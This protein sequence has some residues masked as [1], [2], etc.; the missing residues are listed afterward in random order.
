M[1]KKIAYLCIT[2]VVLAAPA[3]AKAQPIGAPENITL[4]DAMPKPVDMVPMPPALG[5]DA[6][7]EGYAAAAA[8]ASGMPVSD[9]NAN[10]TLPAPEAATGEDPQVD[11]AAQ[12]RETNTEAAAVSAC[13]ETVRNDLEQALKNAQ[14]DAM[15][16]SEVA[17]D[18]QASRNAA[19]RLASSSMSFDAYRTSEC[20]RR[21]QSMDEWNQIPKTDEYVTCEIQLTQARIQSLK[22]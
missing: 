7:P 15:K 9:M 4:Q 2:M 17:T 16:K 13:L 21:H 8:A 19:Q 14:T 12:C 20:L 5:Q 1:S 11:L 6:P 3:I 18:W 22:N 10:A